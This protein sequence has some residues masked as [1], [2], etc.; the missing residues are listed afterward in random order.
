[1]L[2]EHR[3]VMTEGDPAKRLNKGLTRSLG[4]L[5]D[6]KPETEFHMVT[7]GSLMPVPKLRPKPHP[8]TLAGSPLRQM[9]NPRELKDFVLEYEEASRIAALEKAKLTTIPLSDQGGRHKILS[10]HRADEGYHVGET[11]LY[12]EKK[13]SMQSKLNA[14][15]M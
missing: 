6:Y 3:R 15:F 13:L 11:R 5:S 1:M 10:R 7:L 14:L 2:S 12:S 4:K 8:L 9:S